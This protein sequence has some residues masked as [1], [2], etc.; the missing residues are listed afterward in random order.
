M[1]NILKGKVKVQLFDALTGREVDRREGHNI[2]TNAAHYL[3][4]GC[5][6]GLDRRTWGNLNVISSQQTDWSEIW[7][8]VFGGILVF[9]S[10]ITESASHLFEPLA[11][12]PVG[13][14]SMLGQD[15]SDSKSGTYN[16]VESGSITDGFRYV[17]DFGTSQGNGTW[18]TVCLTS[19]KGGYGYIEGR[20]DGTIFDSYF[21]REIGTNTYYIGSTSNY[22]YFISE[23]YGTATLSR[24]FL[25]PFN[26]DLHSNPINGVIWNGSEYLSAL[27]T[28]LTV[29]DTD[30]LF[31]DHENDCIYKLEISGQN[32]TVTKYNDEDDLTD[33]T[34]YNITSPLT[35]PEYNRG[36][37]DFCVRDGYLYMG[38]RGTT[39]IKINLTT[40]A[41][42]DSITVTAH[43]HAQAQIGMSIRPTGDIY[44]F[45]DI[46]DENDDVHTI[47]SA[48]TSGYQLNFANWF[49]N[50]AVC[51]RSDYGY[52]GAVDT[53]Y[54]ATIKNLDSPITKDA[55][56]TAKITYEL[57]EA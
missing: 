5:P 14:G 1:G 2:I 11:N 22:A 12:Y 42:N 16:G 40:P 6:Y 32:L 15:V 27:S 56:K 48:N 57:V 37:Y 41:D 19:A 4:N 52:A 21:R 38:N 23:T 34:V 29:A 33:T 44:R 8:Y 53:T 31:I 7:R 47:G 35:V 51:N 54:L 50:W 43:T 45:P 17:Y 30:R 55:S 25:R 9:P 24:L 10:S 3:T 13:Y 26:I 18:D 39:V 20:T 28:V 46:I 36:R 49:N